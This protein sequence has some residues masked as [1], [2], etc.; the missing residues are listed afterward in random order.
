MTD[1]ADPRLGDFTRLR[2][3]QLRRAEDRFVA[4]GLKIIERAFAAGC[5]PRSL[6]LQPRWLAG[7]EPLLAA[8][9]EVPVYVAPERL[10]ERVSGFHVHRGALGCSTAPPRRRGRPCSRRGG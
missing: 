10:I 9:P 1:P 8:H 5:R 2:D 4:E 7:L 6:L 3:A